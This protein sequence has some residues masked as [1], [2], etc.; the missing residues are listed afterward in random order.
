FLLSGA[1]LA[2]T[3]YAFLS[4]YYESYVISPGAVSHKW[5][6]LFKKEKTVP[7]QKSMTLTLSSSPLGKWLHYG[8]IYIDNGSPHNSITLADIQR[9]IEQRRNIERL[10]GGQN[11]TFGEEPDALKLMLQEEHEHLE[12]KST[13]RFDQRQKE[14]SRDMEKAVMKTVAAFLNSKGG[15]LVIGIND[16]QEIIG[17][18]DDYETLPRKNSDGFENHF[19]QIFNKMI[20]PE[21][22]HLVRLKFQDISGNEVC[23]VQVATSARPVYL[24]IDS[25][26]H[27]YVRTGNATTP[28]KL[29]ETEAYSRSR[30]PRRSVVS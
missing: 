24:K 26:E 28:L 15:V 21:F 5:G 4:W 29:S 6:V 7:L 14:T 8:S 12:F 18:R 20:G 16:N 17:L 1:Q 3:V 19:T 27:F 30:W 2:I 9:P 11:Y 25:D 13:L 10:S 22:R 23:L